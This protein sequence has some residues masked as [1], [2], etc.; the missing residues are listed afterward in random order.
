MLL[1]IVPKHSILDVWLSPGYR[2]RPFNHFRWFTLKHKPSATLFA[3]TF[4][5]DIDGQVKES[6]WELDMLPK[7]KELPRK[8]QSLD[9]KARR[10]KRNNKTKV[11]K[12]K[13]SDK[14]KASPTLLLLR[15]ANNEL[16]D[17]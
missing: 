1:T 17:T 14:T 15:I 4:A 10:N 12:Q 7:K 2:F 16:W 11:I 3:F 6:F 8:M 5:A 13:T 9:K